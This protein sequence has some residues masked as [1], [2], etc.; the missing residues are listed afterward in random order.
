MKVILAVAERYQP[1]SV[2]PRSVSAP[3]QPKPATHMTGP[4]PSPAVDPGVARQDPIRPYTHPQT[5]TRLEYGHCL[6][7]PV[8]PS[9]HSANP[10]NHAR[11]PLSLSDN[12]RGHSYAHL[13][14]QEEMYSS[15]IDQLPASIPPQ[16][17]THDIT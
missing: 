1:K 15:P 8:P 13:A 14:G 10:S 11:Y 16:V 4:L 5:T 6:S 17:Y 12:A 7:Q 9:Y 3:E 2:K